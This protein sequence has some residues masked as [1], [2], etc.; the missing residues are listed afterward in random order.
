MPLIAITRELGSLGESIAA[1]LGEVLAVPVVHHEIIDY[2]ADKMRLRRSHVV[3]LIEG[4]ASLF[5]KLTAD[6]TSLSIFTAAETFALAA[7]GAGAVFLTWGAA[8]L[9]APVPHAVRVRICAPLGLRCTRLKRSLGSEDDDYI[10]HEIAASDEAHGAIIRRHFGAN[11]RDPE[12]YDLVLNTARLTAGAAID[13]I[14]AV[15]ESTEFAETDA[16]RARLADL[17]LEAHVRGAL[18]Q[19]AETTRLKVSVTADGG[20]V[21]LS[22]SVPSQLDSREAERVAGTVAGV[23]AVENRLVASAAARAHYAD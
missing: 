11:W 2:L 10:R 16:A 12:H 17:S 9:L 1:G 5:E 15:V 6:Q 19:A 3:K 21:L 8:H 23:T 14:L 4:R 13:H 22:G 7:R 20:R 18:R